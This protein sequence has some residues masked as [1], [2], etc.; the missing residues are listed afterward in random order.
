MAFLPVTEAHEHQSRGTG[1]GLS[2]AKR[3]AVLYGGHIGAHSREGG[4]LEME[5]SFPAR[6]T[7]SE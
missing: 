3:I 6:G 5:I 4:G 7:R 2:I 1:L